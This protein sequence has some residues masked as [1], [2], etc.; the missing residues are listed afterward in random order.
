MPQTIAKEEGYS[1]AFF[2][3]L[4]S[5]EEKED[6]KSQNPTPAS[7]LILSRASFLRLGRYVCRAYQGYT[8]ERCSWLISM[9]PTSS[10]AVTMQ[11]HHVSYVYGSEKWDGV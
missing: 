9:V 3:R 1:T 8:T 7:S 6:G 2:M 4:M 5:R 11:Q 10:L